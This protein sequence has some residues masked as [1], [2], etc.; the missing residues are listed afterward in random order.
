LGVVQVRGVQAADRP[1]DEVF[2]GTTS[3]RQQDVIFGE[4]RA[5]VSVPRGEVLDRELAITTHDTI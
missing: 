4:G 3:A 5:M 1:L 2:R